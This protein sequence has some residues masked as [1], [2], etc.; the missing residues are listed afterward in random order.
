M[1]LRVTL[2]IC[3]LNV[4]LHR[5]EGQRVVCARVLASCLDLAAALRLKT[6]GSFRGILCT[7][8]RPLFLLSR[9]P[10]LSSTFL[11]ISFLAQLSR[12]PLPPSPA[13]EDEYA[14]TVLVENILYKLRMG[15]YCMCV[16]IWTIVES[17][18]PA[19]VRSTWSSL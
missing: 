16:S 4:C 11:S 1:A 17:D 7:P 12:A 14:V 13:G 8:L 10:P 3:V 18:V 9:G 15:P 6:A 5:S 2:A 19:S